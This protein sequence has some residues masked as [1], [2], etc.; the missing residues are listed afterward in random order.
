M[1]SFLRKGKTIM[2]LTISNDGKLVIPAKL[3]KKYALNPGT[4]VTLVDYGSVLSI[5]P[6][7]KYPVKQV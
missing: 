7:L 1:L 4:E 6:A 2:V 5:V 3:R